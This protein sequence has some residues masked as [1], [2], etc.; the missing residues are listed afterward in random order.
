MP[1]VSLNPNRAVQ[2]RRQQLYDRYGGYMTLANV[3]KELGASRPTALKFVADIPAYT[4]VGRRLYDIADI[5]RKIE[6]CRVPAKV[7]Q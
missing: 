5:A 6:N 2:D 7:A 1:R 3:M 4:L